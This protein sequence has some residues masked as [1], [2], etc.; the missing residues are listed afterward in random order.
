MILNKIGDG[1]VFATCVQSFE[2]QYAS[3][4]LPSWTVISWR[5]ST[6]SLTPIS[7]SLFAFGFFF[8]AIVVSLSTAFRA[9]WICCLKNV[10]AAFIAACS[11]PSSFIS[12]FSPYFWICSCRYGYGVS[13]SSTKRSSLLMSC[14]SIRF[15]TAVA[16]V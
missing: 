4:S 6:P 9:L 5:R 2:Y 11:E 3:S 8:S 1:Q 15:W 12:S 10:Y 14:R 13:E 7:F 16:I